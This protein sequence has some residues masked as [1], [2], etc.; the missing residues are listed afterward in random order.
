MKKFIIFI[1]FLSYIVV[2]GMTGFL[3]VKDSFFLT[4][5][6]L[7]QFSSLKVGEFNYFRGNKAI[8]IAETRPIMVDTFFS[9]ILVR[10]RAQ[11]EQAT[12]TGKKDFFS[13]ES[14]N[15]EEMRKR[16][17]SS[18]PGIVPLGFASSRQK[19]RALLI[20][21]NSGDG[22]AG[23][24]N[25]FTMYPGD[26]IAGWELQSI[27]NHYAVF[28]NGSVIRSLEVVKRVMPDPNA[29]PVTAITRRSSGGNGTVLPSIPGGAVPAPVL[30]AGSHPSSGSPSGI[31]PSTAAAVIDGLTNA[32][33]EMVGNAAGNDVGVVS[34][35]VI[36]RVVSGDIVP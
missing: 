23:A 12:Q 34:G 3:R 19:G 11:T 32:V 1:L 14:K 5:K 26:A 16:I 31:S 35:D 17:E 29:P 21:W 6:P 33:Q 20:R 28:R 24:K 25:T 18:F 22:S 27:D 2:S 15:E 8:G 7:P 10:D 4:K 30:P 36:P 9:S 13:S